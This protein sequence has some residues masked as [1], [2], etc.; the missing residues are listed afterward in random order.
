MARLNALLDGTERSVVVGDQTGP[1]GLRVVDQAERMVECR[2][3]DR[4]PHRYPVCQTVAG[5]A[6]VVRVGPV[7]LSLDR[8]PGEA[9]PGDV[10]LGIRPEHLAISSEDGAD[11]LAKVEIVEKL[12]AESLVYLQ[13]EFPPDPITMRVSPGEKVRPGDHVPVAV[14]KAHVHLFDRTDAAI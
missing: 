7:S 13:S 5:Q 1:V 4:R 6:A 11:F 14:D 2:L 9:T 12:G 8:E 3:A 10:T